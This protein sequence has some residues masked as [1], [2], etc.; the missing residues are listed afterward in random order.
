MRQGV[1]N[2][3]PI[4]YCRTIQTR[5]T[6][7]LSTDIADF[8]G[9]LN[10]GSPVLYE[11]FDLQTRLNVYFDLDKFWDGEPSDVDA[12]RVLE[13]ALDFLRR[14]LGAGT[15]FAV[16]GAHRRGK[17]SFHIVC[18][19]LASTRAVMKRIVNLSEEHSL[20]LDCAVYN[21]GRQL[22]RP[23]FAMGEKTDSVPLILVA[24]YIGMFSD[25]IIQAVSYYARDLDVSTIPKPVPRPYITPGINQIEDLIAEIDLDKVHRYQRVLLLATLK[26]HELRR[27]FDFKMANVDALCGMSNRPFLDK[28]WSSLDASSSLTIEN[29]LNILRSQDKAVAERIEQAYSNMLKRAG[30][31]PPPPPSIPESEDDDTEEIP[32]PV[33]HQAAPQIVQPSLPWTGLPQ[34]GPIQTRDDP[35]MMS[36]NITRSHLQYL[37][38]L[39]D[40]D[41]SDSMRLRD[42]LMSASSSQ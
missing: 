15:Q 31:A 7:T 24:P 16:S 35:E 23:L 5:P 25:H 19:L 37:A 13:A 9:F 22:M 12:T 33:I 18:P 29:I 14:I 11:V 3:K 2:T 36:V 38:R 4:R 39:I 21:E 6:A 1:S 34:A 30:R 20:G 10:S 41:I 42:R 28:A 40:L 32:S 27:L 17:V 26:K 8:M